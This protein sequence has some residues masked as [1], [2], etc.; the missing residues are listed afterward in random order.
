LTRWQE[1]VTQVSGLRLVQETEDWRR[2]PSTIERF[3]GF[4]PE[5]LAHGRE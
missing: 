5:S 2:I 1:A 4:D 3:S